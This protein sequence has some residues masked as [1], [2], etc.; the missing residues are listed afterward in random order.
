MLDTTGSELLNKS[1]DIYQKPIFVTFDE[2]NQLSLMAFGLVE[3]DSAN[4]YSSILICQADSL[5]SVIWKTPVEVQGTLVDIIKSEDKQLA[6]IN[7]K[8]YRINEDEKE[9]NEWGLLMLTLTENGEVAKALP[10]TSDSNF[11]IDRVFAISNDEI[12]LMGYASEPENTDGKLIY[13]VISPEG[14]IIF[15]NL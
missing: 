4:F 6:F 8:R 3:N 1:L 15:K 9:A 12:S 5:G 7:F 14:N 11:H 10:I 13:I 2:I